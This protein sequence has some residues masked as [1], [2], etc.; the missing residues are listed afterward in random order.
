MSKRH[1]A[2][3]G[4]GIAGCLSALELSRLPE[5]EV[6]L[7]ERKSALLGGSP[8]CHLHA[9]GFLYPDLSIADC[10]K[11]L[12]DSLAFARRFAP[13][14]CQRPTIVAYNAQSKYLASVLPFR[15]RALQLAYRCWSESNEGNLPLGKVETYFA[16]Y[17]REDVIY[18]YQHGCLPDSDEPAKQLHKPFVESFINQLSDIDSIKYPFISVWEPGIKQNLLEWDLQQTIESQPNIKVYLNNRAQLDT[19]THSSKVTVNEREYD[20]L[21]NACGGMHRELL[22]NS[23]PEHLELKSA[24]IIYN[25][26]FAVGVSDYQQLPEIAIVG[27]RGTF[28]GLLQITPIEKYTFQLHYMAADSTI[29]YGSGIGIGSGIGSKRGS[30]VADAFDETHKQYIHK[31]INNDSLPIPDYLQRSNRA[32]QQASMFF[33]L[34]CESE[35]LDALWGIQR[36]VGNNSSKRTSQ[37][38]TC[39][40]KQ[41]ADVQLVKATSVVTVVEQLVQTFKK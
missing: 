6:D 17:Q 15:G 9:G 16:T 27:E 14:L 22:D 35:P 11:L 21:V 23:P 19:Q 39:T 13:F 32:I 10:E 20:Y 26:A 8:Y 33:P 3:I 24:W 31:T 1:V 34:L 4:G 12:H 37:V 38:V 28:N 40:E 5:V 7:Y 36:T 30:S 18:F 41:I 29:I 2:V 25:N